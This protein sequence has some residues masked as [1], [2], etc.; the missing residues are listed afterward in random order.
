MTLT[1]L[2][3]KPTTWRKNL[4]YGSPF[5]SVIAKGSLK[6]F[7]VAFKS[8]LNHITLYLR[9][10]DILCRLAQYLFIQWKPGENQ[11]NFRGV[12]FSLVEISHLGKDGCYGAAGVSI[13]MLSSDAA[14]R[15][16]Y[17]M[18]DI[19]SVLLLCCAVATTLC[20]KVIIS[21]ANTSG[22]RLDFCYK[23]IE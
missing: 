3:W 9:K 16:A 14:T 20:G 22:K 19:T 8:E 13:D 11:R 1:V 21:F 4:V 2:I 15:I 10:M 23:I 17:P 18:S 12:G 5:K 6:P 7:F